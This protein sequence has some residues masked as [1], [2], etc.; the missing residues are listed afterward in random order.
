M[1]SVDLRLSGQ[2]DP[3]KQKAPDSHKIFCAR[4]PACR[5]G[6]RRKVIRASLIARHRITLVDALQIVSPRFRIVMA[7][8]Q[9]NSPLR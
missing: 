8:R 1:F 7:E 3:K 6:I 5:G 9:L 4:R 2:V